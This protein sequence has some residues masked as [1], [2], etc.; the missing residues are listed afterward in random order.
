MLYAKGLYTVKKKK[1]E[2]RKKENA[3]VFY[4]KAELLW[5]RSPS[6]DCPAY[7]QQEQK[8][9]ATWCVTKEDPFFNQLPQNK[10][11]YR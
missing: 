5:V 7:P 11:V 6:D 4:R 10:G 9:S 2:K 3:V 8:C 1:K